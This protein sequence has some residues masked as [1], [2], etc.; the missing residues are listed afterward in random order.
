[1]RVYEG[2]NKP[3]LNDVYPNF[4]SEDIT[5][6]S[7]N[8]NKLR[9]ITFE[10]HVSL[11]NK[12]AYEMSELNDEVVVLPSKKRS[13]GKKQTIDMSICGEN[14]SFH[15]LS[16]NYTIMLKNKKVAEALGDVFD[17]AFKQVEK[18]G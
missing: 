10:D 2:H 15:S 5:R 14:I 1:M 7:K 6:R 16:D 3:S 11:E 17:L 4:V 12:K 8:N 9:L 13:R 18:G